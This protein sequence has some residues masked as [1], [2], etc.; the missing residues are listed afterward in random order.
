MLWSISLITTE[1]LKSIVS[2]GDEGDPD[3]EV[4]ILESRSMWSVWTADWQSSH[5]QQS[6]KQDKTGCQK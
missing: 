6:S 5:S 3:R 4:H 2:P 1:I